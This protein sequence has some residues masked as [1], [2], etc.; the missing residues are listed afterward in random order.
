MRRQLRR[1]ARLGAPACMILPAQGDGRPLAHVAWIAL[2]GAGLLLADAGSLGWWGLPTLALLAALALVA[3][4]RRA[5]SADPR[6]AAAGAFAVGRR[7]AAISRDE[8]DLRPARR[9]RRRLCGLRVAE[10]VY[11][12]LRGHAGTRAR[13]C[14]PVRARGTVARPRGAAR[15]PAHRLR[16]GADLRPSRKRARSSARASPFPS[17]RISRSVFGCPGARAVRARL[18]LTR[19]FG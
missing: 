17:G 10:L 4:V 13:R 12:R 15:L 9:R 8:R 2:A 5:L 18:D 7:P 11:E 1:C 14:P 3:S 19:R 6:R 16:L